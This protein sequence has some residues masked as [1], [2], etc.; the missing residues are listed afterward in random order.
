LTEEAGGL[1]AVFSQEGQRGKKAARLGTYKGQ[2]RFCESVETGAE[3]ALQGKVLFQERRSARGAKRG[4]R[5][6]SSSENGSF[7]QLMS[8]V[9]GAH[10][11]N[12]SNASRNI[13]VLL[14]VVAE[15]SFPQ[16][17]SPNAIVR[18]GRLTVRDD[19][20]DV[21]T[22]PYRALQTLLGWFLAMIGLAAATGLIRK[23]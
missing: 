5:F 14:P 4:N 6:N 2:L 9:F 8:T 17:K 23:S 7:R 13:A 19:V 11:T 21:L 15:P 3:E 12:S 22:R 20:L 16:S 18:Y 1:G 10:C